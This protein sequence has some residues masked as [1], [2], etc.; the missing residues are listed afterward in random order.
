MQLS[1]ARMSNY[2]WIPGFELLPLKQD[3]IAGDIHSHI[4][5]HTLKRSLATNAYY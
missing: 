3:E 4:S 1:F 2:K 5:S